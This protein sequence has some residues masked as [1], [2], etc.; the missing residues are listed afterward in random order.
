ML[1]AELNRLST[2][3]ERGRDRGERHTQTGSEGG[4][5]EG[6]MGRETHTDRE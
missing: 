2:Q 4:E 3:R 5:R 6:E 1:S